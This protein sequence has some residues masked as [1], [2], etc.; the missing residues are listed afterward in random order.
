MHLF[1]AFPVLPARPTHT[2]SINEAY[3]HCKAGRSR[4]VAAVMAYLIHAHYWPLSRAY[5][6]S[7]VAAMAYPQTSEFMAFKAREPGGRS[8]GTGTGAD[9]KE[10]DNQGRRLLHAHES[11]PS[12]LPS[13]KLQTLY[14]S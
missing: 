1:R 11:L 12:M 9:D 5:R 14:S 7:S 13:R 3:V 2:P 6:S 10:K 8:S 4:S